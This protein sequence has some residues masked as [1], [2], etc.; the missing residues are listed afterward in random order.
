VDPSHG[1]RLLVLPLVDGL[2]FRGYL[3]PPRERE[4]MQR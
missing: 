2:C 3:M 4:V 1:L